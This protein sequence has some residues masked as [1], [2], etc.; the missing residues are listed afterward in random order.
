[1]AKQ[2][3]KRANK[4]LT[5]N[6]LGTMA[7]QTVGNATQNKFRA[8]ID[9]QHA[10]AAAV[11][12][13]TPG[14]LPTIGISGGA[15][16]YHDTSEL[17]KAGH[18]DVTTVLD[19]ATVSFSDGTTE[20]NI[21][22]SPASPSKTIRAWRKYMEFNPMILSSMTLHADDINTYG[23]DLLIQKTNPFNRPTEIPVELDKF[24]STS[25]FQD[26]KID[27]D[28]TGDELEVSDDVLIKLIVPAACKVGVTMRFA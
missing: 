19:D 25:Q 1:M 26:G 2:I 7:I 4:V 11:V 12:A 18:S 13:I 10:N 5:N 9:N 23:G 6:F 22:M 3:L 21:V 28:F 20:G 17:K 15:V 8:N 24:F 16:H 27:I 14:H